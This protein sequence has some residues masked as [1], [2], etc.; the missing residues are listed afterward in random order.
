MAFYCPCR[1][2]FFDKAESDLRKAFADD[3]L[4]V[5]LKWYASNAGADGVVRPSL[6]YEINDNALL[7]LEA[8]LFYGDADGIFGQFDG[9]DRVTFSV[10]TAF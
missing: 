7:I 10:R 9:R 1:Y 8:D 4:K 3:R 5:I 2:W 6:S